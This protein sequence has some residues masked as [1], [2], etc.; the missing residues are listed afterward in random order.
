MSHNRNGVVNSMKRTLEFSYQWWRA[1]EYTKV[2]PEHETALE[3]SAKTRIA[4]MVKLGM[5]EGQLI[6]NIRMTD[7]DP[8]E[9]VSYLG[10]WKSIA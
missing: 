8:E 4:E 5:V 6:E 3:E 2:K 10:Y 9:G 1:E 7:D